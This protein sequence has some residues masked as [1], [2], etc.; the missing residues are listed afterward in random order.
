[1]TKKFNNYVSLILILLLFSLISVGC[2][3]SKDETTPATS[4]ET[5]SAIEKIKESKKIVLG[6][7]ADYPPYEFHKQI[8]G[9]DTIVGFDIDIAKEVAK[10]LGVELEIKDMDFNGLL[11]ALDTE[12]IDFVVAG[13]VPTEKRKKSVNFSKVYYNPEQGLLVRAEDK[14]KYKSIEDLKGMK[15]GAQKG[16]MQ[17]DIVLKVFEDPQLKAL[18]KITDLVLELKNKKID[19]V[20]LA[21]PAAIAY[22]KS[23]P[24]LSLS[25][26]I[27]FRKEDGAPVEDGVAIAIK[28]GEK[29]LVDAVNKTID[30]LIEE[31]L[32][33]KFIQDATVLSEE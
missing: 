22:D 25:P 10:D 13:M 21:T 26:Y 9:K 31:K 14:E 19:G 30:R 11:A 1:M 18:G 28:K 12:N 33:E 7:C 2:S 24:D 16:T 32:L 15:V 17:E 4:N 6:T 5:K 23:N 8:N 20:V 29:E 3:N 27:N